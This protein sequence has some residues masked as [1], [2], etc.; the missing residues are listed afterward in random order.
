MDNQGRAWKK[1]YKKQ[2]WLLVGNRKQS[3]ATCVKVWCFVD[4]SPST[5]T[6]SQLGVTL[7]LYNKVT[8]LPPLLCYNLAWLKIFRGFSCSSLDSLFQFDKIQY[9]TIGLHCVHNTLEVQLIVVFFAIKYVSYIISQ[10]VYKNK[11]FFSSVIQNRNKTL[12]L[13]IRAAS[14]RAADIFVR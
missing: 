12:N 13:L 9:Y 7:L 3:A 10:L 4:P 6:S 2:Q 5:L 8:W 11:M 14:T 1:Q